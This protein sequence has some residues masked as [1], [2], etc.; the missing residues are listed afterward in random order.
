MLFIMVKIQKPKGSN[1]FEPKISTICTLQEAC[2]WIAFNQPPMPERDRHASGFFRP[3]PG[4]QIPFL[5]T[6]T[7]KPCCPWD[8]YYQKMATCCAKLELAF[9]QD[10][11]KVIGLNA[12]TSSTQN[13]PQQIPFTT[14]CHAN[15]QQNTI[16]AS[17]ITFQNV[18]INFKELRKVF[19]GKDTWTHPI[20]LILTYEEDNCIYLDTGNIQKTLIKAFSKNC[21]N[22][23]MHVIKYIMQHPNKLVTR[24]DIIKAK[25]KGFDKADRIDTILKN[26]FSNLNIYKYFFKKARSASVIFIPKIT[27]LDLDYIKIDKIT[28]K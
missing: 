9:I 24:D 1:M 27:N 10:G 14:D 25:I 18:S 5:Q 16:C 8:E 3:T 12:T 21:A 2:E 28:I 7:P 15:W 23:T 13:V 26:V 20:D 6:N 11:I 22:K 17:S 19:P 4:I